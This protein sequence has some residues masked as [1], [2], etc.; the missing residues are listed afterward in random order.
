MHKAGGKDTRLEASATLDE[1][2]RMV[3]KVVLHLNKTR[4]RENRPP[5]Y[6]S[7]MP[8]TPQAVWTWA[9]RSGRSALQ[10]LS[11]LTKIRRALLVH[12]TATLSKRGISVNGF[13]YGGEQSE[14]AGWQLRR[15]NAD[16]PATVDI[17]L[18]PADISEIYVTPTAAHPKWWKCQ[19]IGD[20]ARFA[21]M[22][23]FEAQKIR[24]EEK[25]ADARA[26]D[27]FYSDKARLNKELTAE[28][29]KIQKQTI[30]ADKGVPARAK[31][32]GIAENRREERIARTQKRMDDAS[33]QA[34][35]SADKSS[36][37]KV[38]RENYTRVDIPQ[39]LDEMP[40]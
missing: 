11:D 1:Y 36:A 19:L 20:S 14:D 24:E 8:N 34:R 22:S 10:N 32:R 29:Q 35:S 37:E 15:Y 31:I 25:A 6:P 7:D 13:K 12:Q 38:S 18:D 3:L 9:A 33:E 4:V 39:T 23:L 21:G 30:E 16:R 26:E 5:L 2:M 27:A 17:A 28:S 40:D